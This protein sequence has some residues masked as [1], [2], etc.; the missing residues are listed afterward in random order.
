MKYI[1]GIPYRN[2]ID[3]LQDAI[4]SIKCY[5][6]NLVLIDNSGCQELSTQGFGK[7]FLIIEPIVPLTFTQSQNAFIRI[8][9]ERACD[10]YMYMHNDA[11][12]ENGTPEKMLDFIQQLF[13]TERFWGAVFTNAVDGFQPDLL[14]AYN[15]EAVHNVGLYD[16]VFPDYFTDCDYYRRMI[17]KGY[18]LINSG[19]KLIHQN[20][21]SN[22]I[23]SDYMLKSINNRKHVLYRQY[24][25][26]KWGGEPGREFFTVPFNAQDEIMA[27]LTFMQQEYGPTATLE[28]VIKSHPSS[29]HE[30]QQAIR[31][32]STV[33]PW[34]LGQKK[35][36]DNGAKPKEEEN[37]QTSPKSSS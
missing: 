17:I 23:N 22:T 25:I 37:R 4:D 19:L 7:D 8:A 30:A 2:R 21:G 12:A 13:D 20:G 36:L 10:F 29:Y 3:L 15:M 24:Y 28:Q 32:Y 18:E 11:V 16:T 26:A 27:L 34:P 14:A 35:L 33:L 5:W 6:D 1:V 9:N 31:K